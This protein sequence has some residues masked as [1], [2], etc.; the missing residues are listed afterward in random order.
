M[1]LK[2]I[3]QQPG[4]QNGVPLV[5][6]T[7]VPVATVNALLAQG[8]SPAEIITRHPGLTPEDVDA[9]AEF[10]RNGGR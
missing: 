2:Q 9:C 7:E 10:A 5:T 8:V 1:A 3:S 6:G 4:V